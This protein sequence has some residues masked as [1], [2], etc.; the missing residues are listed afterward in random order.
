MKDALITPRGVLD[1]PGANSF[2]A[3]HA[4]QGATGE[5][6]AVPCEGQSGSRCFPGLASA[7]LAPVSTGSALTLQLPREPAGN[8]LFCFT[9]EGTD[10]QQI[11]V[12][13]R[14]GVRL[15]GV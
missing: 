7:R 2:P 11:T 12:E 4:K 5:R 1:E 6:R 14:R 8:V 3:L 10:T 13:P 15:S 9:D